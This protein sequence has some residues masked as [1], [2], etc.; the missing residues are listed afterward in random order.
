MNSVEQAML[1]AVGLW[2]LALLGW[3]AMHH[4]L[5]LIAALGLTVWYSRRPLGAWLQP[6]ATNEEDP[7]ATD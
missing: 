6:R 4:P 5:L 1:A 3:V 7:H 2:V